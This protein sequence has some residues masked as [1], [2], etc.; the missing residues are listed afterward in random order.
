[1]YCTHVD[2]NVALCCCPQQCQPRADPPLPRLPRASPCGRPDPPHSPLPRREA[3]E[4]VRDAN[5]KA[6]VRGIRDI[7]MYIVFLSMFTVVVGSTGTSEAYPYSNYLKKNVFKKEDTDF[8]EIVNTDD[9]WEYL[10]GP[11]VDALYAKDGESNRAG[12]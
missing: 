5:D 9:M 2:Q 1:M 10:T 11:F 7:V 6:F 3:E 12:Y 4:P 8:E